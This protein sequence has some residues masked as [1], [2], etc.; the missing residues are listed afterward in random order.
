MIGDLPA[1]PTAWQERAGV[2]A[3]LAAADHDT[4]PAVLWAR[5]G[6]HGVGKTQVAAAYARMRVRQGWPVVVW[7]AAETEEGIVTALDELAGAGGAIRA[8]AADRQATAGAALRWLRAQPGP[9]LLIY[10]D[11]GD[12]DLIRRWTPAG[13][14]VQTVVTTTRLDLTVAGRPARR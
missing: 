7:A 6:Q 3:Q 5:A 14:Q 12:G 8:A 13:G 1:A 2:L 9:C 10:D 4:R 11:A